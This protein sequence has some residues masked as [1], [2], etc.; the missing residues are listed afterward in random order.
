MVFASG[1]RAL[2][3]SSPAN[4][5]L[6][7]ALAPWVVLADK[8]L[9]AEVDAVL[10][11][12]NSVEAMPLRAELALREGAIIPLIE[13]KAGVCNL[14]RLVAERALSVNTTAAGGNAS[15]MSLTE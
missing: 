11:A 13:A 4:R 1:N 12:G 3:A 8:P 10:H 14:Y 5:A 2:L 15:L 7:D 9:A 6:A